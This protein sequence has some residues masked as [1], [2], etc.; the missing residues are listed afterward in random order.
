[1]LSSNLRLKFFH[2][3]LFWSAP[4]LYLFNILRPIPTIGMN[5]KKK[6]QE[7]Y[8]GRKKEIMPELESD[9]WKG[10]NTNKATAGMCPGA[11]V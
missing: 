7:I 11:T 8:A 1:M 10:N 9:M 3:A 4:H 6:L 2:L 5:I